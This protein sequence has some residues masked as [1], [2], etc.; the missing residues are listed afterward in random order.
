MGE[1][2]TAKHWLTIKVTGALGEPPVTDKPSD[3]SAALARKLDG[4]AFMV[5]AYQVER[6]QVGLDQLLAEPSP[7]S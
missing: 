5:P 7:A 6:L 1:G 3:Q 4:W 2:E